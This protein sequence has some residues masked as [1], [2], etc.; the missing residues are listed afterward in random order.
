MP[1]HE[2]TPVQHIL[3][4]ANEDTEVPVSEL[5]FISPLVTA[6]D[7]EQYHLMFIQAD[8]VT[9]DKKYSKQTLAIG[10]IRVFGKKSDGRICSSLTCFADANIHNKQVSKVGP[11]S[12]TRWKGP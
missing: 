5:E 6:S 10:K 3:Y 8:E 11:L 4:F 7:C 2:G 9:G 12:I 1:K